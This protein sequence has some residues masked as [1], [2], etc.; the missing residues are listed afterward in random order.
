[1]SKPKILIQFDSSP[2]ASTFDSIVAIDSGVNQ[3]LPYS[4][5]IPDQIESLVHGAMFTRGPQDL[6]N[7]AMFFGGN[8]V[9]KT[10]AL[11]EAAKQCFFGPLRTS[12]LSDPNGSNT[13]AAAAVICAQKHIDLSGKTITILAG[14]GPVGQRVAQIVAGPATKENDA[15]T[16][17]VCSRQIEKAKMVCESLST[18]SDGVFVA[19]ETGTSDEALAAVERAD[20][21][22]ATGA[23]GIEL[24]PPAWNKQACTPAVAI[25][26]NAVPPAGIAGIEVLDSGKNR[27]YSICYGAIGVGGLKMKIHKRALQMLFETND[28]VLEVEEIYQVGLTV[29]DKS[30][31]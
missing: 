8:D 2:Q 9:E 1:M 24:L 27:G 16:I 31:A 11:V 30:S 19:T 5:V 3:L 12:I 14:T 20:V 6:K 10:E 26:L 28:H 29:S 4:G 22:F 13:T 23:A 21:V 25:D 7:T 17:L 18:R 15:P